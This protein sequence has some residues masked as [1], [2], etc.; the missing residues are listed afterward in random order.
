MKTYIETACFHNSSG[1][2]LIHS[3]NKNAEWITGLTDVREC[4]GQLFTKESGDSILLLKPV[5]TGILLIVSKVIHN[6]YGDNLTAYLHLPLGLRISGE[7]LFGMVMDVISSLA[8]NRRDAVSNC[9]NGISSK[10]FEVETIENFKWS[11]PTEKKFAYRAVY[12]TPNGSNYS[13]FDVLANPFQ[14]YYGEFEYTYIAIDDQ[15][16]ANIDKNTNISKN[17]ISIPNREPAKK[18]AESNNVID[19][20]EVAQENNNSSSSNENYTNE[21]V[22][23]C[24]VTSESL[25]HNTDIGGWLIL[26]FIAV[27]FGG[28]FSA[29]YPI[30]TFK[31]ED[32]AGNFCLASVDIITGFSLLLVAIITIYSFVNRKPNAVFWGKVYVALIFLT[33]F[34]SIISGNLEGTGIQSE[35]QAI[36]GL[37]WG[38]IWFLYLTF[39]KQ[40]NEIIPKT[41]RKIRSSD[42]AIVGC[43]ILTPVF[44]YILG[45]SQINKLVDQRNNN[46]TELLEKSLNYDE[47]TDGRVIFSIPTDFTCE[48]QNV[49]VEGNSFKIFNLE[50]STDASCTIS[51]D[52]DTDK[53]DKNFL[54][55]WENWKDEDT[56]KYSSTEID[57]GTITINGNDCK[58]KI[59]KFD[60]NG[61]AVYWRF[62]LL[63]DRTTGKVFV[64]TCYD[65]NNSTEYIHELLNSIRFQ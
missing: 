35:K 27:T 10:E 44:M 60:I 53:S 15:Y 2:T 9:L 40:V 5:K 38:T 61:V 21:S 33:N 4:F 30:A 58:Y 54:S 1:T 64:A 8:Q 17:V 42:W 49:D 11:V 28:I 26:F 62:Y 6:R 36:K 12:S 63:F 34:L 23:E 50:S 22:D 37:L 25:K 31:S 7:E 55:Y 51:S 57:S 13:I 48:E 20:N 3:S 24:E 56:N 29:I 32:Y 41:F 59:T 65:A 46:E 19:K 16:I 14:E 45:Y 39:S 52:Y 43:I 47:R 18:E